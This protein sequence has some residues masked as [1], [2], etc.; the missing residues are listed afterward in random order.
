MCGIIGAYNINRCGSQIYECLKKVQN[1]GQDSFGLYT[2]NGL[3]SYKHIQKGHVL[4]KI[5]L[6][7]RYGLGQV[8]YRTSGGPF[9]PAQP[10][11]LNS[12]YGEFA[13]VH[14][15]NILNDDS[16]ITKCKLQHKTG[17]LSDSQLIAMM[18]ANS[19]KNDFYSALIEIF[20]I[21]KPTYSILIL[22]NDTMY[23]LRDIS[24][25]RP[26]YYGKFEN[27]MIFASERRA[28]N[29]EKVYSIPA[30]RLLSLNGSNKKSKKL[31]KPKYKRCIFELVYLVSDGGKLERSPYHFGRDIRQKRFKSGIELANKHPANAD[32]VLGIVGSGYYSALGYAYGSGLIIK[33]GVLKKNPEFKHIRTFI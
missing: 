23:A 30:G 8:R 29:A 14:N 13:L 31:G 16:L 20:K 28:I 10:I 9:H 18:I 22:H 25:N 4:G 33:H 17:L 19:D 26:L 2:Y 11:I 27:G 15:G 7:G 5:N 21:I 32:F 1:R 24:G 12:K 6:K 3:N